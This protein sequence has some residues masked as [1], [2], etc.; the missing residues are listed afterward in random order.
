MGRRLDG[1]APDP[2]AAKPLREREFRSDGRP[3]RETAAM[4]NRADRHADPRECLVHVGRHVPAAKQTPHLHMVEG[5]GQDEPSESKVCGGRFGR[6][7][8]LRDEPIGWDDDTH[9]QCLAD[10]MLE[11][12]AIRRVGQRDPEY[13]HLRD[14]LPVARAMGHLLRAAANQGD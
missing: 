14:D 12:R 7:I 11:A 5:V 9:T 10:C 6:S 13:A 1:N 2:E 4:V 8:E 3:V